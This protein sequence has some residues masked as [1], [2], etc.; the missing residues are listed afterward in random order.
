MIELLIWLFF[1]II[2]FGLFA[3]LV[4]Y[5]PLPQPFQMVAYVVL[6]MILILVLAG[7]LFGGVPLRPLLR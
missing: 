6:L 4:Q 7:L 5:L 3:Y 1:I 2:I